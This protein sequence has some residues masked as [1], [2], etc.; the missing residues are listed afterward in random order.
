MRILR[1]KWLLCGILAVGISL[2][3]I[4]GSW[5]QAGDAK[6]VADAQAAV[7]GLVK[8]KGDPR[9]IAAKHTLEDVMRGF[10]MRNK[11][12]IGVGPG[13]GGGNL[14]LD[15]I[16]AKITALGGP[17]MTEDQLKAQEID[18]IN[19]L[20]IVK[21]IGEISKNYPEEAKHDPAKW[22]QY[23][24]EM[25]QV[26]MDAQVAVK[27]GNPREVKRTM[28]KLSASCANC[29]TLFRD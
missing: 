18:L 4:K 1:T 9:A 14:K 26:A 7:L 12:G 24:E 6:A 5:C 16:E 21:A 11:G 22:K 10:K 25:I 15:G 20:D 3:A 19:M 17:K 2:L 29:H 27:K 8:G 23:T 13:A 28:T